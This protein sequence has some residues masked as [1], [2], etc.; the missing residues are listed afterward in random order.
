MGERTGM[1]HVLKDLSAFGGKVLIEELKEKPQW[2]VVY[3]RN[4]Q[5]LFL[6]QDTH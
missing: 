3:K 1:H 4:S 2:Q 5:D 6:L